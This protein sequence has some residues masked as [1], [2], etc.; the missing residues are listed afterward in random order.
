MQYLTFFEKCA[1]SGTGM[2]GIRPRAAGPFSDARKGTKSAHKGEA[3]LWNPRKG[4]RLWLGGKD[5]HVTAR[6]DLFFVQTGPARSPRAV[7]QNPTT[8]CPIGLGLPAC[9]GGAYGEGALPPR[10]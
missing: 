1:A 6:P 5:T 4:A 2:R 10:P 3:P 7:P 9:R 8:L